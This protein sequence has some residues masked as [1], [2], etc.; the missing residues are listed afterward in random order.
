MLKSLEATWWIFLGF[1]EWIKTWNKEQ[2]IFLQCNVLLVNGMSWYE[3][4]YYFKT[5]FEN[6]QNT[7][8]E[9]S[10]S[11]YKNFWGFI[12]LLSAHHIVPASRKLILI[13][14]IIHKSHWHKLRIKNKKNYKYL[15]R[16]SKWAITPKEVR[17]V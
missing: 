6:T 9:Q 15:L 7:L 8:P 5:L 10:N 14:K 2:I 1:L 3:H 11:Q 16:V 12:T 17:I 4:S 13:C